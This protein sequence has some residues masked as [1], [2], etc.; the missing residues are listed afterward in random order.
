MCWLREGYKNVKIKNTRNDRLYFE[1][2]T[3]LFRLGN[4]SLT[5]GGQLKAYSALALLSVQNER[6]E[7]SIFIKSAVAG[8]RLSGIEKHFR[9]AYRSSSS[10]FFSENQ[11]NISVDNV[12]PTTK[13]IS[14]HVCLPILLQQFFL[15]GPLH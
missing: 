8:Q 6:Q 11:L 15:I 10:L 14:L 2:S 5:V 3:K 9:L 7:D 12:I 4:P 13:S 1:I